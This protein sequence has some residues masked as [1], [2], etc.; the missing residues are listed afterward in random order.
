MNRE[1]NQGM[2]P[3]KIGSDNIKCL[4]VALNEQVKDV[5]VKNF[6]YLEKEIV[7]DVKVNF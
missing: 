2:L 6:K 3:F 7:E 4:G 5:Y 1:R